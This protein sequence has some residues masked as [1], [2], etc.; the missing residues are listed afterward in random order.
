MTLDPRSKMLTVLVLTSLSVVTKDPLPAFFLLGVTLLV[1]LLFQGNLSV[2]YKMLRLLPLFL[3][4]I[5]VHS[6]FSQEGVA[7]L[8]VFST[9]LMTTFGVLRVFLLF[10]RLTSIILASSILLSLDTRDMI[11]GL[12]Q[13]RIPYEIA[14]MVQL[15][16][17]FLPLLGQELADALI[18]IQLRGLEIARLPLKKKLALYSYLFLPVLVGVLMKARQ[19]SMT[20]EMRAF[21]FTSRR[22]SFRRLTLSPLD[23]LWSVFMLVFFSYFLFFHVLF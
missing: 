9:P 8:V 14:F 12:I 13:W 4:L 16:L 20:L 10:L 7:L 22:T 1:A 2:L 23:Y 15:G 19:I 18:A 21:R 6:F 3:L 11:Q 17:S 5:P